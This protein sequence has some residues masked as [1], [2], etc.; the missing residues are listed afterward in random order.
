MKSLIVLM[1]VALPAMAQSVE[2]TQC[3]I[4]I[5]LDTGEKLPI[6]EN[7]LRVTDLGH[8]YVVHSV[9][10]PYVNQPSGEL[11]HRVAVGD[12]VVIERSEPNEQNGFIYARSN[13]KVPGYKQSYAVWMDGGLMQM[14]CN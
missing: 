1:L 12:G 9:K 14:L 6:E 10:H 13:V 8:E 2:Y 4:R 11:V 5:E 7:A 3:D